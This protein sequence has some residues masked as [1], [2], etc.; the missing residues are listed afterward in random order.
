VIALVNLHFITAGPK[1]EIKAIQ[2]IRKVFGFS[3]NFTGVAD[4]NDGWN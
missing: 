2:I 3:L 1:L 4:R